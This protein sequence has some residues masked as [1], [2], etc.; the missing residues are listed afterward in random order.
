M[1]S[2]GLVPGTVFRETVPLV[3]FIWIWRLVGAEHPHFCSSFVIAM[4]IL[5]WSFEAS[6]T[7]AG[8]ARVASIPLLPLVAFFWRK[9]VAFALLPLPGVALV[10]SGARACFVCFCLGFFWRDGSLCCRPL[11]SFCWCLERLFCRF[12][13]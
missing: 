1:Y 2:A 3:G 7:G 9:I 4:F 10:S 11:A 5:G 12:R 6:G 13:I 8:I